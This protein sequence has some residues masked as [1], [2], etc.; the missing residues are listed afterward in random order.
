[1]KVLPL[2]QAGSRL[3]RRPGKQR[4][5]KDIYRTSRADRIKAERTYHVPRRHLL[6]IVIPVNPLYMVLIGLLQ[7][8]PHPFF[9]S[10]MVCEHI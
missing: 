3:N 9:E 5:S 10:A 8:S 1:M 4:R 6:D 2:F 7:D